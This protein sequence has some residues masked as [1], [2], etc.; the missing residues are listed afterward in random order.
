MIIMMGLPGAG[1]STVLSEV[2]KQKPEYK[3]LN[4]GTLMF[5]IA[6][7]KY[8]IENRDQ[9]RTLDAKQQKTVQAEVGKRLA[10]EKGKVILDTHCSI[11]NPAKKFYLPGLPYSLLKDIHVDMLI[12]LTGD[13]DELAQRRANDPS[14]QRAVDKSEIA[15]HDS[16][17]RMLLACYSALSGA[18]A[19][20]IL[21]RNGKVD[22]AVAEFVSVME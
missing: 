14:R 4:Y 1:K 12:L 19:K 9:I 3:A 22:E 16:H 17:N 15:S 2:L 20:I 6:K 18:P 11:L 7:E 10:K 13:I 8:G 21:N 5:D